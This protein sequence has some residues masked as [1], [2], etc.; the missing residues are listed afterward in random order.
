MASSSNSTAAKLQKLSKADLI[1]CILEYEKYNLGWPSIDAILA[2]IKHKN[3]LK[4][5]G[6]YFA[7][8]TGWSYERR[9]GDEQ[10]GKSN[11]NL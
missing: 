2:D 7:N 6:Y 3:N 8:R 1:W 9:I 10:Y 5:I 4:K 11:C